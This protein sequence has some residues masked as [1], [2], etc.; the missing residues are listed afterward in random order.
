M[1]MCMNMHGHCL[2]E[3]VRVGSV[4]IRVGSVLTKLLHLR[5]VHEHRRE[6]LLDVNMQFR[7]SMQ[8]Y[9]GNSCFVNTW[10]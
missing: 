9:S 6:V 4:L 7:S 1:Y 8:S 10:G 5:I 2:T 3:Q